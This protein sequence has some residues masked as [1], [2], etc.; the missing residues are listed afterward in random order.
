MREGG[1][2]R[3]AGIYKMA[4]RLLPANAGRGPSGARRDI[5]TPEFHV[6][7]EAPTVCGC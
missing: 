4:P 5:L 7:H 2:L 3:K 6:G 1:G